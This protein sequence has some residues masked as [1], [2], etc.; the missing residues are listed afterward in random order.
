MI[1]NEYVQTLINSRRYDIIMNENVTVTK[2]DQKKYGNKNSVR[3]YTNKS[4]KGVPIILFHGWCDKDKI[5]DH[6]K[7]EKLKE[8][9][10]YYNI[11]KN[12]FSSIEKQIFD[13]VNEFEDNWEMSK[14]DIKKYAHLDYIYFTKHEKDNTASFIIY[15]NNIDHGDRDKFFGGHSLSNDVEIKDGKVINIYTN[16]EG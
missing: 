9:E 6:C 1:L 16:L 13:N 4:I 15:Y 14:S 10:E 5:D 11:L 3:I 12:N 2:V 8:F 7:E